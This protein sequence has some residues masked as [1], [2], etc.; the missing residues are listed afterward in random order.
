MNIDNKILNE[1]DLKIDKSKCSYYIKKNGKIKFINTITQQYLCMI[2][3]I[4][5]LSMSMFPYLYDINE[6]LIV[7]RLLILYI[8]Q[9]KDFKYLKVSNSTNKN[10]NYNIIIF[11]PNKINNILEALFHN[12]ITEKTNKIANFYFGTKI[13]ELSTLFMINK[14]FNNYS[15]KDIL[16]LIFYDNYIYLIQEEIYKKYKKELSDF[17]NYNDIYIFL[18]SKG[19]VEKYYNYYAKKMINNYNKYY[20]KLL[21]NDEIEIFKKKNIKNIKNFK[22]INLMKI[23]DK[24]INNNFNK[25]YI[26]N[27]FI[28]IKEKYNI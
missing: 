3:N 9:K 11:N 28:E 5:M 8:L 22:D 10:K 17:E 1:L 18:K 15:T 24:Y 2:N 19:Y 20:E 14:L 21:D 12:Y 25:E 13:K 6:D 26:K 4:N 23:I 16:I 7:K 27:K